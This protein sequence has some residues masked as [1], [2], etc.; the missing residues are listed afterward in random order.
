MTRRRI[1]S[2]VFLAF[3]VGVALYLGQTGPQEQHVNVVLG[4]AAPQ[5][6]AVGLQYVA[7][8]GDIANETRFQYAPGAAPRVVAH[9]PKLP[10]GDYDLKVEI[11]TPDGGRSVERRVTLHGGS[12]QV[13]VS[14]E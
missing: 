9:A 8:G 4:A 3:G 7:S 12:T 14:R 10:R 5:V 1:G 2:L 13:D 6:T 11:G